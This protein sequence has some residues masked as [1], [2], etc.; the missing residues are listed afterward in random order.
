M[1]RLPIFHFT[2]RNKADVLPS[3]EMTQFLPHIPWMPG[4]RVSWWEELQKP[5][6]PPRGLILPRKII[7]FSPKVID[8][9]YIYVADDNTLVMKIYRWRGLSELMFAFHPP[10]SFSEKKK[11]KLLS[12]SDFPKL[13]GFVTQQKKVSDFP[14]NLCVPFPLSIQ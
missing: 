4:L 11:P 5:M 6:C 13:F 10:T 1:G 12:F 14:Y 3:P 2:I 8:K 7:L 9:T